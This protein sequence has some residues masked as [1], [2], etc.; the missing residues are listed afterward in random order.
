MKVSDIKETLKTIRGGTH[1]LEDS[2]D[3]EV[4]EANEDSPQEALKS[5]EIKFPRYCA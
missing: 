1:N 4:L 5:R 3:K 2:L